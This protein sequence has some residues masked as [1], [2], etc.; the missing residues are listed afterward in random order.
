MADTPFGFAAP[1]EMSCEPNRGPPD[2]PLLLM[3]HWLSPA[4]PDRQAA[5]VVN[6]HDAV[7]ERA[8]R[9]ERERGRLPNFVA[10][11]FYGI[12]DVLEAVDTL[13]GVGG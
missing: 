5:T 6:A 1:E 2:A 9:C 3:N 7:V 8:R 11:D 4:A 10:V 13:N 12:G